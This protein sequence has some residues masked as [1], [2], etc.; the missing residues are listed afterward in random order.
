MSVR[1]VFLGTSGSVPTL[2]RG[3][4][5]LVVVREG[6]LLM[7]DCGEGTQRQMVKAGLGFGRPMRIFIS[8]MHS[9]HVLGLPGLLQTM[10]MMS[11]VKPLQLYG[12]PPL[13]RFLDGIIETVIRKLDYPLEVY[14][15]SEGEVCRGKG[16]RV[17]AVET[18]HS[19]LNLSYAIIEDPRPGR[20]YRDKA[21]ALGVPEG[22]LWKRLQMGYTVTLRDGRVVKPEDVL[23]PPR[24]G[25]KIVYSGDTRPSLK[26]VKLASGADLLIHEGTFAEELKDKARLEGHSTVVD[27]AEVAKMANVARL[28]IT[29]ISARYKDVKPLLEQAKRVFENTVIAEDFMEITLQRVK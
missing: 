3:L 9:D 26:L 13:K 2:K 17:Q 5:S 22:P 25:L 14:E 19:V 23:G 8:H 4:P 28:A 12:P 6:E 29:H 11:R 20:F 15:V 7:F 10:S 21:I 27:A 16:Y 1:V 18:D 24:R